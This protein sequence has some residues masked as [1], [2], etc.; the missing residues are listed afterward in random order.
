VTTSVLAKEVPQ[1]LV[2]VTEI[3]PPALFGVAVIVSEV[4]VPAQPEGSDQL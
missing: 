4:E 1:E 3:V 2:P